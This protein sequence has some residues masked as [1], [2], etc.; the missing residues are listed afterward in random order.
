MFNSLAIWGI[1]IKTTRG[2]HFSSIRSAEIQKL[3]DILCWWDCGTHT[4]LVGIQSSTAS[5]S[6][7]NKKKRKK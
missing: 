7:T 3:G 2:H 5:T 1:Q 6:E 4:P